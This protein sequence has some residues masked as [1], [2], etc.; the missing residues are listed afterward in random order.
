MGR[1]RTYIR[2]TVG[3]M[4]AAENSTPSDKRVGLCMECALRHHD[5][6][7]MLPTETDDGY[8]PETP[9]PQALI[10]GRRYVLLSRAWTYQKTCAEC[11]RDADGF[12]LPVNDPR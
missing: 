4:G 1:T 12:Y 9:F 11:D 7:E 8:T 10:D 5:Y 3:E 2:L 6:R